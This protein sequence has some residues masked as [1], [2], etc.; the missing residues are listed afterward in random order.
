MPCGS[1]PLA[2]GTR[3]PGRWLRVASRLIPARAG[4][5]VKVL[6]VDIISP[7]HPRSRGEHGAFC[8]AGCQMAG[9]SPLA[10][11]TPV[12]LLFVVV[13]GRLIPARAGNT[14]GI[15][16]WCRS[17]WAHPRSREEH[18]FQYGGVDR[19]GGSSPLARGTHR[20]DD[21]AGD[22]FGLIPAR[23]GNTLAIS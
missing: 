19:L 13:S 11:G 6:E 10:R 15:M 9:S 1:S 20:L 4:N 7:A 12:G 8:P 16:D 5:T 23:A 18:G 3:V 21:F 22:C 14:L 17:W 2:R